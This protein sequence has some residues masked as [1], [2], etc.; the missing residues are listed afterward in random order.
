MRGPGSAIDFNSAGFCILSAMF[1]FDARSPW[2]SLDQFLR[3]R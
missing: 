2:L 3:F 1:F